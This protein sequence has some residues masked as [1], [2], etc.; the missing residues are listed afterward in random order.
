MSIKEILSDLD[1][2]L[3]VK[4]RVADYLDDKLVQFRRFKSNL[5]NIYDF[6]ELGYYAAEHY[7]N[8]YT[9]LSSDY[10]LVPSHRGCNPNEL[11]FYKPGFRL[12]SDRVDLDSREIIIDLD[13]YEQKLEDYI[14]KI[15]WLDILKTEF[16]NSQ[17]PMNIQLSVSTTSNDQIIVLG[18]FY[19]MMSKWQGINV[20]VIAKDLDIDLFRFGVIFPMI[21]KKVDFS[22]DSKYLSFAEI[23]ELVK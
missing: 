18:Y 10:I 13:K 16:I 8:E 21:R 11:L 5:E 20:K 7:D 22:K 17:L 3:S 9:V 15:N 4:E 14:H 6:F 23:K 12:L 19:Y 1:D 2:E